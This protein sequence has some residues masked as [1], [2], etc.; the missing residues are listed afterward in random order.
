MGGQQS[1]M[2][3][4]GLFQQMLETAWPKNPPPGHMSPLQRLGYGTAGPEGLQKATQDYLAQMGQTDPG[5]LAMQWG[6]AISGEGGGEG[7][8]PPEFG[9]KVLVTGG[10]QPKGIGYLQDPSVWS[11]SDIYRR[12]ELQ[13]WA[14][15]RPSPDH[16]LVAFDDAS[17]GTHWIHRRDFEVQ[18][19]RPDIPPGTRVR[20]TSGA[21]G[22]GVEGKVVGPAELIPQ[23][24][25]APPWAPNFKPE[26][27]YYKL[28]MGGERLGAVH[29]DDFEMVGPEEPPEYLHS[30]L[31]PEQAKGLAQK[32]HLPSKGQRFYSTLRSAHDTH[33]EL[34]GRFPIRIKG[35]VHPFTQSDPNWGDLS[36]WTSEKDIP[37]D[38]LEVED[39]DGNWVPLSIIRKGIKYK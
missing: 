5:Q 16:H 25:T 23:R 4:P 13:K 8:P 12:G 3:H 19:P 17:Q 33:E 39:A 11:Y 14:R 1:V 29:R 35:D 24:G 22:R 26:T 28:D 2:P 10:K 30:I 18:Q 27:D 34:Y 37:T 32:T 7:E 15:E 36:E 21:W 38:H 31:T 9:R 20:L 6:M